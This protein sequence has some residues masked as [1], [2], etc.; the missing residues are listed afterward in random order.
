M[1]QN[2]AAAWRERCV[3]GNF[4]AAV[5]G[6]SVISVMG[7]SGDEPF[8][9]PRVSS[10]AV[11]DQPGTLEPDEVW[12]VRA[13]EEIFRQKSSG[14]GSRQSARQ[15]FGRNGEET[16]KPLRSFDPSLEQIIVMNMLAGG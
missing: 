10:L 1:E 16:P 14:N 8:V 3:K 6:K 11:L 4:S 12:A 7:T 15:V 9:F 13:A 5:Q 2:L